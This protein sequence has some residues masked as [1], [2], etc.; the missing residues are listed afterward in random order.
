MCLRPSDSAG[1]PTDWAVPFVVR[2]LGEYV[3]QTAL[4]AIA[5]SDWHECIG[6]FALDGVMITEGEVIVVGDV[7]VP[8]DE[9]T[10]VSYEVLCRQHHRRGLTA[11]RA[12]AVSLAPIRCRS[13][14]LL[15]HS[16]ACPT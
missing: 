5:A 4:D 2:V 6:R 7:D 11:A 15:A 8:V 3:V 10:V 16:S 1:P 9:P 12:H 14:D 13:A